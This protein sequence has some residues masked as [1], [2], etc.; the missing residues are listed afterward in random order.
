MHTPPSFTAEQRDALLAEIATK[1]IGH[2]AASNPNGIEPTLSEKLAAA[3][4]EVLSLRS[5]L[6]GSAVGKLSSE[7]RT[8]RSGFASAIARVD[9]LSAQLDT[10]KAELAAAQAALAEL[11]GSAAGATIA[12]VAALRNEVAALKVERAELTARA[13]Y[14]E[15][16]LKPLNIKVAEIMAQVGQPMPVSHDAGGNLWGSASRSRSNVTEQ[17]VAARG[18][19]TSPK[20]PTA[21]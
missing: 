10:T 9:A 4:D 20:P 1:R 8:E 12:E 18:A 2:D 17:C 11:R 3:L 21:R 14:A 5:A 7:L 19:G 16:E 15:S 13:E 6:D